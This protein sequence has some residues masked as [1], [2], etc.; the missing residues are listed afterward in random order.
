MKRKPIFVCIFIETAKIKYI[1]I[2]LGDEFW[3]YFIFY[4]FL[5]IY[6]LYFLYDEYMVHAC[7]EHTHICAYVQSL[8]EYKIQEQILIVD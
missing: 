6:I 2:F 3:M 4:D 1:E 8:F 5:S 7:T